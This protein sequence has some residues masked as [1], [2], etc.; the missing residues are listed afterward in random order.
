M[1]DWLIHARTGLIRHS[2]QQQ[3]QQQQ[4]PKGIVR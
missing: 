2:Y 1:N 3:Q 4:A